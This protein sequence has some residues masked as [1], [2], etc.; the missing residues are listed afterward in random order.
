MMLSSVGDQV[1][2]RRDIAARYDIHH[3]GKWPRDR[4]NEEGGHE[5]HS[6]EVLVHSAKHDLHRS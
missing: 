5:S 2:S 6:S 3:A 4:V 1:A